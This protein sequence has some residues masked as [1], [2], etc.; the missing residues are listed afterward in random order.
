MMEKRV[1]D[2]KVARSVVKLGIRMKRLEEA[3]Q[4]FKK[5][6]E[7]RLKFLEDEVRKW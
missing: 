5:D 6:V 3:F 4:K 7:L 2:L 1:A